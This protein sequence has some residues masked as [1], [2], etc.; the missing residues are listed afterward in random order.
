M[1]RTQHP[2]TSRRHAVAVLAGIV[3]IG[4]LTGCTI[5]WYPS[6]PATSASPTAA[7]TADP[8]GTPEASPTSSDTG[9]VTSSGTL[10]D[11]IPLPDGATVIKGPMNASPSGSVSGW[12]ALAQ[13]TDVEHDTAWIVQQ[14][15]SG[16]WTVTK[17]SSGHDRIVKARR[18]KDATTWT[19]Q[20]RTSPADSVL[21]AL[22]HIV[23]VADTT[24]TTDLSSAPGADQSTSPLPGTTPAVN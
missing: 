23:V 18:V 9:A 20:L 16:G 22:M 19:V 15:T 14:L 24:D 12:W 13:I 5:P 2:G 6:A 10:P 11:E 1:T 21:P 4:A 3:S 8:A 17:T 7:A